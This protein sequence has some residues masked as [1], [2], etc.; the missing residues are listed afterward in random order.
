MR[1]VD[2][3]HRD[4]NSTSR[5]A[6]SSYFLR[7]RNKERVL[8]LT[9]HFEQS[10]HCGVNFVDISKLRREYDPGTWSL[11]DLPQDPL[12]QFE[13]WFQQACSSG[14]PE[15]NAMVLAT[16]DQGVPAQRTVLLKYFDHRGFVFFTNYESRKA[17]H[18]GIN[19]N[20]S[21]LFPWYPLQRQVEINGRA[22]K[23]STS[24]SLKYFALRPRNAQLG[25]WAS[26]QS[27]VVTTTGLIQ[28]KL[29]E[30]KRKFANGE[31][32]V[33]SFWGGMR[34]VPHRFEFWQGRPSRLH[35]RFHYSKQE[36]DRWRIEQLAP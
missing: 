16:V 9:I 18:I 17:R 5:C 4:I 2:C 21:L 14:I 34:V 30:M 26:P 15:P 25:A 35:D 32:P 3:S 29:E 19:A 8:G 11:G 13:D 6:L 27:S 28:A 20:V 36:D 31:V 10:K 24:E 33:P 7:L 23:V 12:R 1:L 22:E